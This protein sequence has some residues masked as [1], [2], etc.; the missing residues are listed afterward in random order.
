LEGRP[1]RGWNQITRPRL[2]M[3]SG[4][5]CPPTCERDARNMYPGDTRL[6]RFVTVTLGGARS[7]RE[8]KLRAGNPD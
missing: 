7:R 8:T 5:S 3:I 2:S 1:G 6:E 4:P